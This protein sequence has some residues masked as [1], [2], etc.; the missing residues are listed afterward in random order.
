LVASKKSNQ[1]LEP[2]GGSIVFQPLHLAHKG[3]LLHAAMEVFDFV[4]GT[5]FLSTYYLV[6]LPQIGWVVHMSHDLPMIC[7]TP[8]LDFK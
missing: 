7:S 6:S 2:N 3:N 8:D 5:H 4:K 1:A